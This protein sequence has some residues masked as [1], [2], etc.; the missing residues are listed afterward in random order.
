MEGIGDEILKRVLKILLANGL[1]GDLEDNVADHEKKV[2]LFEVLSKINVVDAREKLIFLRC[3]QRSTT[4]AA[5]MCC[6][7]KD[8]VT[9]SIQEP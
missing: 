3:C 6:P 4:P 5:P 7:V 1:I 2:E 8:K 9:L